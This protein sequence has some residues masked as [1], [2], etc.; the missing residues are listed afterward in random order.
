VPASNVSVEAT[1]ADYAPSRKTGLRLRGGET[2]KGVT[3]VL[4]AGLVVRGSVVD[5][6]GKPVAGAEIQA[7]RSEA[8]GP[9]RMMFFRAVAEAEKPD[10]VTA[11]DG[12][13][14]VSGLEAGRYQISASREGY[15]Q[16]AP[17][18]ADVAAGKDNRLAPIVLET[19]VAIAGKVKGT[20]GEPVAGARVFALAE[21]GR[22]LDTETGP[23][24][25]F[26]I[27][28]LT[29][30]RPVRF[31]ITAD[32]YAQRQSSAT[33]PA[34]DVVITLDTNG[35]VRGRVEDAARQS[36]VTDFSIS[37]GEA[38]S[39]GGGGMV[40]RMYTGDEGRSFHAEDGAFELSN[41]PPGRWVI[42]AEAP[43][44]R[45]AEVAGIEVATGET[46]EGVVLSMKRGGSIIGRV[47]ESG[48][49]AGVPNAS[50]S[51][52]EV[53]GGTAGPMFVSNAP[54][55]ETAA[56]AD[57][58]FAFDALPEGKITLSASHPD[59][60]EASIEVDPDRQGTVEIAL[61]SGGQISGTVVG[62]DGRAPASGARVS[63]EA[64]GEAA[65]GR[66]GGDA[67]TAGGD[68]S[69]V[70]EHL[71]AGR[72]ELVAQGNAGTSAPKEI[73]LTDGQ[74]MDG[75]LLQTAGGTLLR[76][77]V[78]GLPAAE[79]A[80]VR[81]FAS[82]SS[83]FDSTATDA[84]GSFTLP[85][86]PAGVIRLNASTSFLA[87]RSTQKTVEVP[88]G[89][90][91][92]PVE[93]AFEGAARLSGQVSRAGKPLPG[94]FVSASPDPP[95][96]AARVSGQT[97]ESGRYALEGLSDGAYRLMVMGQNV[98]FTKSVAV[99]GD[100]E[101]DVAIPGSVLSG[102]VTDEGTGEPLEG[103]S[104]QAE[105]GLET[106]AFAVKEA[107]S[108]SNGAWSIG[109]VEPGSYRVT[110]RKSGYRL[111]TRAVTVGAEPAGADFALVR[112][113]G[114][115]I[116]VADGQTGIPL[117]SVQ[118]LAFGAG[119]TIA[120]QGTVSL[121]GSGSGEVPSLSDGS[122]ALYVFSDGYA[123]RRLP[124]VGVPSP[125]L[126]L[127]LTPGGRVHARSE[128]FVTGR[129][130]DASGAVVLLSP[131]RLDGA[132]TVSPPVTLW[133][134]LPPGSYRFVTATAGGK[135]YAFSVAEG[136]TTELELN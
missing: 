52:T 37:R 58:R 1:K 41:V 26:R 105:T 7:Q 122:Y 75:V 94:L 31:F 24:G 83:Y 72:Y 11:P 32:G 115:S 48:R 19:G 6:E 106:Q 15:V 85:D 20:G 49:G 56:D 119:G 10:A 39:G 53:G 74:R 25:E 130:V 60:L 57:G 92:L 82:G 35:T 91:E 104:V 12:G 135:P 66:W 78:A 129:L 81:I 111:Q 95:T 97:D 29:A 79:L 38:P 67:A 103:A 101:E 131:F 84:E 102:V 69:F 127:A 89:T 30:G 121:D 51:W 113:S 98:S 114:L 71:R 73:V 27:A 61:G 120:F 63:L 134:H 100:S 14:S 54:R 17:A 22:P 42:R 23:G 86:V 62:S 36:P 28:G 33:P 44:Y 16:K 50:I 93:I 43:G 4:R 109:D 8:G 34:E 21:A 128:S 65:G 90:A 68:G 3:L 55:R 110:A 13:F 88:S 45:A 112:G 80:G 47:V 117:S 5:A 118:V 125:A 2:L 18:T 70:F 116:R 46:K 124:S 40:M 87:G 136:Q 132:V 9:R 77:S 96:G 99:S 133:E 59:Y 126:T 108:D 123:A 64:M 76:G 107:V